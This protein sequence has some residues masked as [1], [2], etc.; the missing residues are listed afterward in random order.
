[1][2]AAKSAA[3]HM[4]FALVVSA[5]EAMTPEDRECLGIHD[6]IQIDAAEYLEVPNPPSPDEIAKQG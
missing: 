4:T 5:F 2:I 3:E 6:L 1:L